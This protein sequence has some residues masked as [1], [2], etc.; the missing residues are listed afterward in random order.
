[1]TRKLQKEI[2][3]KKTEL[4]QQ[5][6]NYWNESRVGGVGH[7]IA[8]WANLY[9]TGAMRILAEGESVEGHQENVDLAVEDIP[10]IP[11]IIN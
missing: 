7:H 4:T 5:P 2:N 3:A 11:Q 9:D 8:Q 10:P 1:M 6:L